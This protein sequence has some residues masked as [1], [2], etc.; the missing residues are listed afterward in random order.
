[1]FVKGLKYELEIKVSLKCY[2]FKKYRQKLTSV[3]SF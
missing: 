3:D 1:M 2:F